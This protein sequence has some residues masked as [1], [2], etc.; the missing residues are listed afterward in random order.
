MAGRL[1]LANGSAIDVGQVSQVR[2]EQVRSTPFGAYAIICGG[3]AIAGIG[4][5][6]G[7]DRATQAMTPAFT[8]L[9]IWLFTVTSLL[10]ALRA[11]TASQLCNVVIST[12]DGLSHRVSLRGREQATHLAKALQ[13]AMTVPIRRTR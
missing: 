1:L 13:G 7:G 5:A 10:S 3:L 9:G 11:F 8:W 4:N 2:A 12:R 6:L